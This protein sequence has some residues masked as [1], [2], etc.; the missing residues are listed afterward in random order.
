MAQV[1]ALQAVAKSVDQHICFVTPNDGLFVCLNPPCL[2]SVFDPFTHF[3]RFHIGFLSAA[4]QTTFI[5]F[6][7]LIHSPLVHI[8]S[9]YFKI[10]LYTHTHTQRDTLHADNPSIGFGRRIG[11]LSFYAK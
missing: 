2:C 11:C 6:D 8:T 7:T 10:H 5:S 1:N 3:L 4:S 9:G